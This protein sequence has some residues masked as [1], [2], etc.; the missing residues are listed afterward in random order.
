MNTTNFEPVFIRY[1]RVTRQPSALVIAPRLESWDKSGSPSQV[2]LTSYLD[3]VVEVVGALPGAG[4]LALHLN[5]GFAE[6]V[7][8]TTGGRDLDNY[9]YPVVRRLGWKRF[10]AASASKAYGPS[11]ICIERCEAEP[12]PVGT[13]SFAFVH[14]RTS[15]TNAAWK[16][17]IADQ[18]P[19]QVVQQAAAGPL[20]V[21]LCFIVSERRNWATLW[22]P[23]IDSLGA[24]LGEDP[25]GRRYHPNDDRIVNLRLHRV[26]D[27]A[28]GNDVR[29]GIWWRAAGLA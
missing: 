1:R 2:A 29:I 19:G 21:D 7:P 28:I 25:L 15:P 6:G 17:E 14:T 18:L 23:A 8:L 12:D 11:S 9:L 27:G 16:K 22:K 24:I 20:D 10:L 13:W 3:H 5:V 4:Q 26:V